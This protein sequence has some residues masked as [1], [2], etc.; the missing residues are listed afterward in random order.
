MKLNRAT[1]ALAHKMFPMWKYFRLVGLFQHTYVLKNVFTNYQI[2]IIVIG[3]EQKGIE[4]NISA[5]AMLKLSSWM[6][7]ILIY[8][9]TEGP[10]K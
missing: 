6:K 9:K 7:L 10:G 5:M 1:P 8:F 3:D 4:S 2:A